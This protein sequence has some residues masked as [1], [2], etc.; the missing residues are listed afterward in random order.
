MRGTD[1]DQGVLFSCNLLESRIPENHPLRPI[2]KM[3]DASADQTDYGKKVANDKLLWAYCVC[4]TGV[5]TNGFEPP[6]TETPFFSR[7]ARRV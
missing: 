2:R 7:I 4:R 5:P 6:M 1:V 3:V